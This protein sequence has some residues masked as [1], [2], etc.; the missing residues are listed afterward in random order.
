[1]KNDP[2]A[3]VSMA[4]QM[5]WA[6]TTMQ[7]Q[8]GR[9]VDRLEWTSFLRQTVTPLKIIEKGKTGNEV[10]GSSVGS[11]KAIRQMAGGKSA[12]EVARELEVHPS[13]LHRWRRE[14]DKH[15]AEG[16][17]GAGRKT[18]ARDDEEGYLVTTLYKKKHFPPFP[19]GF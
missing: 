19:A 3:V 7:N 15:R 2:E 8:A 13:D 18:R 1:V 14:S 6:F 10:T 5:R 4:D 12:A 16:F 17:S 9:V 11:S